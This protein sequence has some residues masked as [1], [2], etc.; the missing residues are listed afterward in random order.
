MIKAITINDNEEYL[1][2][3]SKEVN[4]RIKKRFKYNTTITK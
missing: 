4:I 1:R 3:I 2:Q